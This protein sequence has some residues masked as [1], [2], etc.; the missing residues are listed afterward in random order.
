MKR[1]VLSIILT[2]CFSVGMAPMAFATSINDSTMFFKQST[3]TTCTLTSA[4]M[5][6]RRRALLD[7]LS[8]WSSITEANLRGTAWSGGLRNGFTY[9]GMNVKNQGLISAGY[10]TVQKKKDYF[11]SLLSQHPEGIV[12]YNIKNGGQY[13]AVL[14]TDYDASSGTFYCADPSSKAASGRIAFGNSSI[15]GSGQDGKFGSIN[16]IWYITNKSGGSDPSTPSVPVGTTSKPEVSVN[17]QT[18]NVSWSYNGSGT[19]IDVYIIVSPWDWSG[20]RYKQNVTGNSCTFTD[21]A[22]GYYN[23][24]TVAQPNNRQ[25]QSDWTE[26]TVQEPHTTHEKGEFRYSGSEHPHYNYY[27][28]AICGEIFTDGSTTPDNTCLQCHW[29]HIWDAGQITQEPA[30]NQPGIRTYTCTICG[31]TKTETIPPTSVSG[32]CGA[33]AY[34]ELADGVLTI[35]GS[36]DMDSY[37]TSDSEENRNDPPWKDYEDSIYHVVVREGIQ[38]IGDAA[39]DGYD[40]LID[41]F[42]PDTVTKIGEG[43]FRRCDNVTRI[44]IPTGVTYIGS[45]A[46][47]GDE[48]LAYVGD[49]PQGVSTIR[50][51]VFGHCESLTS[52]SIPKSVTRI[53]FSAFEYCYGLKDIYYGGTEAHWNSIESIWGEFRDHLS[54]VQIHFTAESDPTPTPDPTPPPTPTPISS[55]TP[56]PGDYDPTPEPEQPTVKFNDVPADAYYADAVSWAVANGV[57]SGVGPGQFGPNM[58]CTRAQMVTFLWKA[59]GQPEPTSATNPF[60]DVK[61]S[62]YCYKAVLWAVENGISGGTDSTHFSPSKS[63]DRAQAVTFI[64]RTEGKPEAETRSSFSDVSRKSYY[65]DA[66]DWAVEYRIVNGVGNGKYH[67]KGVCSRAQIVTML[68]RNTTN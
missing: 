23:V 13:H 39:F 55:P 26:F 66:I 49:I 9:K 14:M 40:N 57:T 24:F 68:Y 16:S 42:L 38:N 32:S 56:N 67:P 47:Y 19:S 2:L 65:A 61:P 60:V 7:G 10:N 31:E 8:D 4:A 48:K 21:V 11:I 58:R 6:L 27:S 36:G 37:T 25:V 50:N 64:W 12:A 20:I 15:Y 43:A 34:W 3:S 53:Y 45:T 29:E 52:I 51:Q 1:R 33:S 54:N 5:M 30:A 44:S 28:C 59:Q 35:S 63:C 22:P 46:F 62:D 18:V 41:V 17:G